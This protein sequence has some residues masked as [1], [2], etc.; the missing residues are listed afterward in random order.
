MSTK[1]LTEPRPFT[2]K[3]EEAQVWSYKV[4]TYIKANPTVYADN[5]SKIYL[6]LGLMEKNPAALKWAESQYAMLANEQAAYNLSVTAAAAAIP[7]TPVPAIPARLTWAHFG[8]QFKARWIPANSAINAVA[9]IA[10]I[11]Q[12]GSVEDYIAEFLT[13]AYDTGLDS[14]VL[15][16]FF[17]NG[18][19]NMTMRTILNS[20]FTGITLEA[21]M[22][23]AKEIDANY[24]TTKGSSGSKGNASSKNRFAKRP[25]QDD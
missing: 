6:V 22:E 7:P 8:T 18:L 25:C 24:Q 20:T 13:I 12:R 1:R 23:K 19:N 11:K 14:A 3:T 10:S 15:V 9:K 16:T 21:W 5:E 4:A 17:K 2:G